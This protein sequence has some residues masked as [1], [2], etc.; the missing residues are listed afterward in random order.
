VRVEPAEA[1][2]DVYV[3]LEHLNPETLHLRKWGHPSDVTGQKLAF[4]KGDVIFGRRRAYQRKL[5]VAEFDG[6]CSAHAMVVPRTALRRE[7]PSIRGMSG[8]T[9]SRLTLPK[10]AGG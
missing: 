1:Q 10:M 6:I 2:T 3:G 4:K 5:A 9:T 8:P 7:G